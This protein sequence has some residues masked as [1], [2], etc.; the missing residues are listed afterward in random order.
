[1]DRLYKVQIGKQRV[2]NRDRLV[3]P[4]ALGREFVSLAYN[5]DCSEAVIKADVPDAQ[6][7]LFKKDKRMTPLTQKEADEIVK[8]YQSAPGLTSPAAPEDM[9]S[10]QFAA[11]VAGGPQILQ[12]AFFQAEAIVL[13]EE[14]QIPDLQNGWKNYGGSYNPAGFRKDRLETVHLRGLIKEGKIGRQA[15]IFQ[16]PADCL[17]EF[18]QLHLV[19]TH[20]NAA[21][22]V[23]ILQDGKVLAYSGDNHWISLDGIQFRAG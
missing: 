14:W 15:V 16:L 17:P 10:L 11:G 21:G 23:D 3:Y 12:P 9:S 13:L 18:R 4:D 19:A 22:R 20:P 5:A 2:G 6:H 1:M 7:A 8:G